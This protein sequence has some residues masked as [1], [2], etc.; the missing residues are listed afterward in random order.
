MPKYRQNGIPPSIHP[1]AQPGASG[2]HHPAHFANYN[3]GMINGPST[4]SSPSSSPSPINSVFPPGHNPEY[5]MEMLLTQ[6]HQQQASVPSHQGYAAYY[7]YYANQMQ[8]TQ[9]PAFSQSINDRAQ[10]TN[11]SPTRQYQTPSAASWPS[12]SSHRP[13]SSNG[14]SDSDDSSKPLSL[15]VRC[16]CS[17][18]NFACIFG[19]EV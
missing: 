11:I 4:T 3:Y 5:D 16:P 12:P 8:F 13:P 2:G 7:P 6:Q 17:R 9:P 15:S 19:S 18:A 14:F 10:H 1:G